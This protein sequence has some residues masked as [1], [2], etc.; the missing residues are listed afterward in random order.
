RLAG[1]EHA[2][3]LAVGPGWDYLMAY[4]GDTLADPARRRQGLALEPM[5]CPPGALAT[6]TGVVVL[7]NGGYWEG[8]FRLRKS[9]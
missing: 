1:P 8:V 3:E 5:T 7:R 2:V 4:S 6:G 9:P